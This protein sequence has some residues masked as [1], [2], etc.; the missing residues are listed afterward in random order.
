MKY[1]DPGW[2]N[3]AQV[4]GIKSILL[5]K[6]FAWNSAGSPTDRPELYEKT[7][8]E[9][10]L[11][12]EKT[13][14]KWEVYDIESRS[15]ANLVVSNKINLLLGSSN[16]I[17]K[18]SSL[19][20][21]NPDVP[22]YASDKLSDAEKLVINRL[23]A[24]EYIIPQCV[25][26]NL[27]HLYINTDL[28]ETLIIKD[29]V[30]YPFIKFK[31]S[32]KS[33]NKDSITILY[34]SLRSLLVF[35]KELKEKVSLDKLLLFLS[36]YQDAL[37]TLRGSLN[38]GTQIFAVK[39]NNLL[40]EASEVLRL[41]RIIFANFANE[42]SN[43]DVLDSLYKRFNSL[44]DIQKKIDSNVWRTN[45][46]S[47]K[48]FFTSI[49]K[50]GYYNFNY[51]PDDTNLNPSKISYSINGKDFISANPRKLSSGWIDLGEVY[52]S[53]GPNEI[54]VIQDPSQLYKGDATLTVLSNTCFYSN[55]IYGRKDDMFRISF[56]HAR[57]KGSKEFYVK[58]L[59]NDEKNNPF[60]FQGDLLRSSSVWTD[61]QIDH[62]LDKDGL[63]HFTVCNNDLTGESTDKSSIVL[64]DIV[65][66]KISVPEIVFVNSMDNNAHVTTIKNAKKSQV[67]YQFNNKNLNDKYAILLYNTYSPNWI[68]NNSN[69][70]HLKL[71]GFAN[72]W[73]TSS[74]NVDIRYRLQNLVKLGFIITGISFI[75]AIVI[76]IKV[77]KLKDD[78]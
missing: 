27:Q 33:Q 24:N 8:H 41:E 20:D 18:I 50:S 49:N 47:H 6:D 11:K 77:I 36:D 51:N 17:G 72:G 46:I 56:S 3:L 48:R 60:G 23:V 2:K 69:N 37:N 62:A 26:C 45:D 53:E 54:E 64:K 30:F 22:I 61:Y 14:G 7:L 67:N 75:I 39:D 9:K 12:K 1:G 10:G 21:F 55:K 5:R 29:S 58:I 66:N 76:L 42:T 32:L 4:L 73:I 31:N 40:I 16:D 15:T 43:P 71:N 74:S 35:R 38:S 25:M 52:L 28:Y 63:F 34:D 78:K 44:T 57:L 59:D 65:I 70:E 68:I 13:F 19:P